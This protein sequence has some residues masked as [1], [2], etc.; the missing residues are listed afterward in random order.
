MLNL[1]IK[2]WITSLGKLNK[3]ESYCQSCDV[4]LTD[5]FCMLGVTINLSLKG[6]IFTEK[7][8][9]ITVRGVMLT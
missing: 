6:L 1:A 2:L 9:E 3:R 5:L 4:N 8:E 7:I